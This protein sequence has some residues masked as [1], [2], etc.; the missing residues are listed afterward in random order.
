MGRI[1]QLPRAAITL[2]KP[3]PDQS[4]AL[5]K[6]YPGAPGYSSEV[7]PSNLLLHH[8][9]LFSELANDNNYMFFTSQE[10]LTGT[11]II[12]LYMQYQKWFESLPPLLAEEADSVPAP[13]VLVFQYFSTISKSP[14]TAN[15]RQ[16]A[17]P[18]DNH[19][20]FPSNA[21]Q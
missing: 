19:I 18:L 5:T 1:S 4:A 7:S 20:P 2:D 8:F 3:V 21:Y 14:N 9:A 11:K 12:H 17:I 15:S 13:H 16:H 10:R 6:G